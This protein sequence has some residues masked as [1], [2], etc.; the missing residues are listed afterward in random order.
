MREALDQNQNIIIMKIV[1]V[2]G[3]GLI[4]TKLVDKLRQLDHSVIAASP[5]TGIDTITGE[6]LQE[7]M[8]DTDVVVDVSN[9]PSFKDKSV[10]DF[11][12]GLPSTS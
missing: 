4:G 1:V 10:M 9:A 2:G 5:T 11:F 12:K 7:A 8:Q 3:T 6:G